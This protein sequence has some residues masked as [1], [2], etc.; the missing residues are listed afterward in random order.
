MK[1][2]RGRALLAITLTSGL[3]IFAILGYREIFLDGVE[4]LPE[5]VCEGAVES[6]TA[7]KVLP[8]T[9]KVT[10]NSDRG[11]PGDERI[12]SCS[13]KTEEESILLAEA[14]MHNA[15]PDTWRKFYA[16]SKGGNSVPLPGE[17]DSL[18][19]PRDA[20]IYIPCT[21]PEPE[22]DSG[23]QPY[24]L[25]ISAEMF[26]ESRV[27]GKELRQAVVDFAFQ[28]AERAYRVAECKERTDFPL[29]PPRV[30][31]S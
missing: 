18:S 11:R 22:G 12:F 7:A 23:K 6:A 24:A 19:W 3:A 10:E 25:I 9:R 21:P 14:R 15:S 1:S 13:L 2:K 8:D 26:S 17:V 4:D 30:T 27:S 5:R 28:V 31:S 29:A 16:S 20:S